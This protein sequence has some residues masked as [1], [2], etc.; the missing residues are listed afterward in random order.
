MSCS[1][2]CAAKPGTKCGARPNS[3]SKW[4]GQV[5]KKFSVNF[6]GRRRLTAARQHFVPPDLKT[7]LAERQAFGDNARIYVAR[8]A[9]GEPI[10]Y[11]LILIDGAEAEYFEAAPPICI[12]S[13][14][15]HMP[16]SGR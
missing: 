8:T 10:A 14:L 6:I 7:L 16:Y 2:P 13:Y 12:I 11:G 15:V 1:P 3:A 9:E 4:I 5:V